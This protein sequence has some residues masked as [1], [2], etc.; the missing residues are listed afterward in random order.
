MI[1]VSGLQL[2]QLL[3][4]IVE[5]IVCEILACRI[6][7]QTRAVG[8]KFLGRLRDEIFYVSDAL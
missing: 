6:L 4:I 8:L 7:Q 3:I 5:L 2:A 1:M